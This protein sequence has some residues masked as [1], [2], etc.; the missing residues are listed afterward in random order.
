MR[1]SDWSSDVCSSDLWLV[2]ALREPDMGLPVIIEEN[3]SAAI[4]RFLGFA[5]A[6]LAHIDPLNRLSHV[7]LA[8]TI[9]DAGH[10]AWRTRDDHPQSPNSAT[11]N[12]YTDRPD[13]RRVG[14]AFVRKRRT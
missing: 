8:A 3:V 2:S 14:K 1:I 10:M 7:A 4:V 13:A 6:A 5:N 11:M 9:L 12:I